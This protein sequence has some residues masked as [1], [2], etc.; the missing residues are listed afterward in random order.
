MTAT[1]ASVPDI[2]LPVAAV[3]RESANRTAGERG[4]FVAAIVTG[5]TPGVVVDVDSHTVTVEQLARRLYAATAPLP[6]AGREVLGLGPGVTYAS[7]ARQL[8]KRW[9]A[10]G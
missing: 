5:A 4:A 10:A 9:K 2:R 8:L 1:T 7:A 3:G 6:E